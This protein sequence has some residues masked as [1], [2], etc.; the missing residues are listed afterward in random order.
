MGNDRTRIDIWQGNFGMRSVWGATIS[1]SN[2][3]TKRSIG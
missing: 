3:A 1:P 2:S